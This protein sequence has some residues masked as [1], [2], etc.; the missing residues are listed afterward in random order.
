MAELFAT[1]RI[2]DIVL[3]LTALEAVALMA[4]HQW[5]GRGI[6]PLDLLSTLAAGVFLMLALRAALTGAGWVWIA[7]CLVAALAAHLLDLARRWRS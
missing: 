4:Y 7:G 5:T 1:G 6:A 3:A 2:V